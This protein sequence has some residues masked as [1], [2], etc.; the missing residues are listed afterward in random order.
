MG[1]PSRQ[2][3]VKVDEKVDGRFV[4]QMMKANASKV[5]QVILV[6]HWDPTLPTLCQSRRKS[7]ASPRDADDDIRSNADSRGT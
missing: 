4:M 7:G 2:L 1:I 6:N 5:T 3:F